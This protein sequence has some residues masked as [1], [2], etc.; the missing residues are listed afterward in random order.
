MTSTVDELGNSDHAVVKNSYW[1]GRYITG[2]AR[3]FCSRAIFNNFK[4]S[5]GRKFIDVRIM[6]NGC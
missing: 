6:G 3:L 4:C 1:K 2:V 5:R